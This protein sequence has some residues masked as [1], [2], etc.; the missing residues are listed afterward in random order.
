M[1]QI[2]CVHILSSLTALLV[3]VIIVAAILYFLPRRWGIRLHLEMAHTA[4][5]ASS[6]PSTAAANG[7]DA[8]KPYP[9]DSNLDA[10]LDHDRRQRAET[11]S[12]MLK[13]LCRQNLLLHRAIRRQA[14]V[15]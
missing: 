7:V 11:E 1:L 14:S 6:G 10:L 2:A 9:S 5:A 15:T 4:G 8:A 13:H 12:E 3:S